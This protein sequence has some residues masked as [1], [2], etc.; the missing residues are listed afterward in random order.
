MLFFQ[1]RIQVKGNFFKKGFGFSCMQ[2][3]FNNNFTGT[4]FYESVESVI[5]EITGR[6]ED[7]IS[8]IDLWKTEDYIS[9]INILF[10]TKTENKLTDFI[11]LNQ[12]N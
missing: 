9:D 7:L 4:L 11:M 1:Y 3:A 2:L 10:K 5:L 12:I 8:A 6:E